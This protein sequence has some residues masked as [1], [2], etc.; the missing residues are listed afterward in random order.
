MWTATGNFQCVGGY[1][2]I[3]E[4][5]EP[6]GLLRMNTQNN[7]VP[8]TWTATGATRCTESAYERAETD[9]CGNTRWVFQ[10]PLSWAPTGTYD[11]RSGIN[12]RQEA[13]QCG[14]IRWVNTGEACGTS[15]H[16]MLSLTP[17][18]ASVTEGQQACWNFTLNGPV[19]GAPLTVSFDLAG[20]DHVRNNYST[21][22]SVVLPVGVSG[23]QLCITTTDDLVIDGTEQLC[24]TPVLTARL[25]NAPGMS[26]INVLDNDIAG[27]DPYDIDSITQSTAD[28]ITEGQQV[29][30]QFTLSR[31][32]ENAPLSIGVVWGGADDARNNYPNS[33]L[34]IPVGQSVGTLCL[35]TIDDADV[36]GTEQLCMASISVN[37]R[38]GTIPVLP[39]VD[40][41]DNDTLDPGDSS[42]AILS[43]V[44]VLNP[45]TE[46]QQGC[47]LVTLDAPVANANLVINFDLSGAD[48][49]RHGYLL[50]SLTIP[51]GD[52]SGTVCVT[53][54]DDV[55]V[56]GMEQLCITALT[57]ARITAVPAASCINVNDNDVAASIHTI[58]CVTP[59]EDAIEGALVC[60][61]FELDAP[62]TVSPLTVTG[63]LSGTEQ[64]IH[65]YTNP[66]VIVPVGQSSGVLCVQT[67]DDVL[68][69]G[70]KTLCLTF[71]T[72]ARVTSITDAPCA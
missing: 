1:V 35:N 16:T 11:C 6:C 12:W 41:L 48:Q 14:D 9:N 13:N 53:T 66:S 25:T 59:P 45:I 33:T 57:S 37:S 18:A 40:V 56:E 50:P 34:V 38:L 64:D 8:V 68:V 72:S 65:G 43:I 2:H 21:P 19:V 67:T 24:V 30:W 26:C 60:W 5:S 42:H 22:R 23:G 52:S 15:V 70:D 7:T 44:P 49:T 47:W 28:P 32:V 71:A 27:E 62:V 29:C 58:T 46:G 20:A 31:V 63:T 69:E 54:T 51:V 4:R 36:D 3:E 10:A 39:C 61:E 17:A 55:V